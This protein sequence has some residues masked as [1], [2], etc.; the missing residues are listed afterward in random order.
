MR[1]LR[2]KANRI[3]VPSSGGLRLG[4]LTDSLVR[5]VREDHVRAYSGNLAYRGLF[6]VFA[7]L[8]LAFAL[9][10]LFGARDL[11]TSLVDQLSGVMP[12]PVV[13]AL[14][15]Q[16]LESTRV[17]AGKGITL[18]AGLA[19]FASFYGLAAT[20]RAVIDGM[21]VMFEVE[22]TRPFMRRYLASIVMAVVILALFIAA[23]L[24]FL[25][26]PGIG[27]ALS[28]AFGLPGV[29]GDV[30]MVLRWLV[31]VF[32]ILFGYA[33]VYWAAPARHIRFRAVSHGS[34]TALALWLSFTLVFSIYV[35]NFASYSVTF[36]ALAGVVVLLLYMFF[37]SLILFMGA[38][39][40]DIISRHKKNEPERARPGAALRGRP[41][42]SDRAP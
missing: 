16:I 13:E 35:N 41:R 28:R 4:D 34:V 18:E 39:I 3:V 8:V 21:N 42:R 9:F 12:K 6:A 38:E 30:L 23:T 1:D 22:E 17:A 40:N 2:R 15:R 31:L 37:S 32:L 25:L 7:V 11:V 10:G 33:L 29:V 27:T 26:G 20:A 24:L 36:G 14:R 19:V 5:H